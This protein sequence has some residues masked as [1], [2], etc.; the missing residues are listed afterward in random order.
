M[1]NYK[2]ATPHTLYLDTAEDINR[3]YKGGTLL[4]LLPPN[5]YV[6]CIYGSQ[7]FLGRTNAEQNIVSLCSSSA[8]ENITG[9]KPRNKEQHMLIDAILAKDIHLVIGAGTAG[10]GKTICSAGAALHLVTTRRYK[11]VV[12]TKPMTMVGNKGGLAAVPG[13]IQ[14]KFAPYL[15]NFTTNFEALI[16]KT[17]I[18]EWLTNGTLEYMPYQ[19]ML[20][21]SYHNTLI[22]VDEAQ[23]MTRA[24]MKLLCTRP[25]EGS[26]V[27]LLGDLEQIHEKEAKNMDNNGMYLLMED[28]RIVN[29]P[30]TAMIN[31][32]KGERSELAN[33]IAEVL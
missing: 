9:I 18:K 33:L 20:G 32:V 29:S 22:I 12:L 11:K 16:N 4:T 19:L 5:S 7:S 1:V 26:K 25:G 17:Y 23:N 10:T 3:L 6:I 2:S 31:L 13:D 24:E 27:L 28:Q 15:I 8:I 14:E 30:I 21:A